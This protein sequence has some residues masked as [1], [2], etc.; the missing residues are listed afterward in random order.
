MV[1]AYKYLFGMLFINALSGVFGTKNVFLRNFRKGVDK[2]KNI[3]Y[4]I[5]VLK[6]YTNGIAYNCYFVLLKIYS[7]KF[8]P[9]AIFDEKQYCI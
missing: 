3:V 2:H 4:N 8:Y 5:G 9:F 7:Y 6:R 1:W